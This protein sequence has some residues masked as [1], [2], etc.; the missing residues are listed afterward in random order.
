[1]AIT[2]EADRGT[3]KR[4]DWSGSRYGQLFELAKRL[5]SEEIGKVMGLNSKTVRSTLSRFR[6][7]IKNGRGNPKV[8]QK[9]IDL[10]LELR[11]Q[12]V[13]LVDIAKEFGISYD[14]VSRL[15]AK[16]FAI[17]KKEKASQWK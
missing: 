2:L 4:I 14:H 9:E 8:G 6:I 10:M 12:N 17:W 1:M 5:T 11:K 13:P 15:T 7:Q 3:R 16:Q